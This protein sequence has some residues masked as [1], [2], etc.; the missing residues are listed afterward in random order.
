MSVWL[1]VKEA[2]WLAHGGHSRRQGETWMH[3]IRRVEK[4]GGAHP[5]PPVT[6][7]GNSWAVE[8]PDRE[9]AE[10]VAAYLEAACGFTPT[11]LRITAKRGDW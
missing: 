4:A 5:V 8:C 3:W 2:K 6:I 9:G 1:I 10:L 7:V 11:M